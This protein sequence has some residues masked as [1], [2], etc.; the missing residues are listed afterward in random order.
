MTEPGNPKYDAETADMVMAM[1]ED[2]ANTAHTPRAQLDEERRIEQQFLQQFPVALN[3]ALQGTG[4]LCDGAL[5]DG[6]GLGYVVYCKDR[7]GR[8]FNAVLTF[9]E[10]LDT[11]MRIGPS[12]GVEIV[13]LVAKKIL[14]ARE[15]YFKR[16]L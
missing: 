12:A 14:D 16:M 8:S 13:K 15:H 9:D 4:I 11:Y 7:V 10:Y 6:E 3:E 1:V 2:S 5:P